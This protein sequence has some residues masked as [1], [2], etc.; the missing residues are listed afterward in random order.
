M[1]STYMK[2]G[3]TGFSICGVQTKDELAALSKEHGLN[4]CLYLSKLNAFR[5]L[6]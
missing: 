6:F 2:I 3:E 5:L 4:S 1:S